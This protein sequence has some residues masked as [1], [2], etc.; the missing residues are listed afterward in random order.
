MQGQSNMQKQRKSNRIYVHE[1]T[2]ASL[3]GPAIICLAIPP[4]FAGR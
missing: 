4:P 3:F 2:L 1:I